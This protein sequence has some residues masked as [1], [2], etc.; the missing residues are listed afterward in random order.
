[1][2]RHLLRCGRAS[3]CR[4]AFTF[5]IICGS[6]AVSA[7]KVTRGVDP[8][9]PSGGGSGG[10]GEP[11]PIAGLPAVAVP[12]GGALTPKKDNNDKEANDDDE[13]RGM[14]FAFAFAGC[15]GSVNPEQQA[16]YGVCAEP[17]PALA[18]RS[19]SV[20]GSSAGTVGDGVAPDDPSVWTP[21]AELKARELKE[22]TEAKADPAAA[23]EKWLVEN[24]KTYAAVSP[25]GQAVFAEFLKV[26]DLGLKHNSDPDMTFA[27]PRPPLPP[28][29]RSP[30]PR[31][32]RPPSPPR[33]EDETASFT[34]LKTDD[35]ATPLKLV[36]FGTMGSLGA[37]T[38]SA[39]AIDNRQYLS[40]S[41]SQG[42]C[43]S[44]W[45]YSTTAVI[46][47]QAST[48]TAK[49]PYLSTQQLV[50][51]S[52]TA[53]EVADANN[54]GCE[55]GWPEIAFS[56]AKTQGILMETDY[57]Y[58]SSGYVERQ[59]P[60]RKTCRSSAYTN[61]QRMFISSYQ[62]I[63]SDEQVMLDEMC[64]R[65]AKALSIAVW[66]CDGFMYYRGGILTH[67]PLLNCS[68]SSLWADGRNRARGAT[69]YGYSW[70]VAATTSN[71]AK[72]GYA[73][74]YD[75]TATAQTEAV[76]ACS[77]YHGTPCT[78]VASGTNACRDA[79]TLKGL[80][81]WILTY[82]STTEPYYAV[83]ADGNCGNTAGYYGT[84]YTLVMEYALKACNTTAR[85]NPLVTSTSPCELV[86][87]GSK[88]AA[89]C[90]DATKWAATVT[91][92]INDT[93]WGLAWA[94]FTDPKCGNQWYEYNWGTLDQARASTEALAS[95]TADSV[96][97]GMG[98][99]SL[100]ASGVAK[101]TRATA[102]ADAASDAYI[103]T[104]Y[105]CG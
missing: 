85:S 48:P 63:S 105:G 93:E 36:N 9:P 74:N 25:M 68:A 49:A 29:P 5:A 33:D 75:N 45:T 102:W 11:V 15:W 20:G 7:Q 64:I 44:C 77:N 35:R 88:V 80:L 86:V 69:E 100:V 28:K 76:A 50:D 71:C 14:A 22:L 3:A 66:V 65:G 60:I 57:P 27:P 12:F 104:N 96:K 97:A 30:P 78:A 17:Q 73:Y 31:P 62:R 87:K 10:A 59:D 101:C 23:Y 46:E 79:T 54:D 56:Y 99:C 103:Y 4:L 70:A 32:P 24:K 98:P 82:A 83:A 89:K 8:E 2:P 18:T 67:R 92:A 41:R 55:G 72:Y 47:A 95:C 81:D 58:T 51:C 1:M 94:V 84:N 91:Q 39:T 42:N 52:I 40:P 61:N 37:A 43:G 53:P 90:T 34:G 19:A 13:K 38:C 21:V 26:I 16:G 6:I